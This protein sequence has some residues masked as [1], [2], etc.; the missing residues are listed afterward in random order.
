MAT[1]PCSVSTAR[2]SL[3]RYDASVK[4]FF[5]FCLPLAWCVTCIVGFQFP[6]DE[7]GWWAL[8]SMAGAW[9][10]LL[11]NFGDI[12]QALAP[13]AVAGV[14]VM[15]AVGRGMDA[16]GAPIRDWT[17]AWI[18]VWILLATG[19]VAFDSLDLV[20]RLSVPAYLINGVNVAL[21]VSVLIAI[22]LA[23]LRRRPAGSAIG[24]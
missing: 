19:G 23:L 6:G 5:V 16:L 14:A 10:A 8:G 20:R 11:H 2:A 17:I 24:S 18:V 12:H 1:T 22:S 13:V 15:A 21:Y 3:T 4:P 7:Y 9:L